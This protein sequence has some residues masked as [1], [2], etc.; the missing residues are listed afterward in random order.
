MLP[1][2]LFTKDIPFLV[3]FP[4]PWLPLFCSAWR[5]DFLFNISAP[6]FRDTR[7]SSSCCFHKLLHGFL[8]IH[9][10]YF[11]KIGPPFSLF[12]CWPTILFVLPVLFYAC[13]ITQICLP[14]TTSLHC[15]SAPLCICWT[16]PSPSSNAI[17]FSR[18]F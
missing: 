6:G 14:Q 17:N 4:P 18:Y 3:Y 12:F 7:F 16:P 13:G 15:P 8:N 5:R 11:N 10:P 9:V 2:L 1:S